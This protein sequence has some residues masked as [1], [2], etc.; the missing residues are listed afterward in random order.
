MIQKDK[1][2]HIWVF[3]FD[4]M[5]KIKRQPTHPGKIIK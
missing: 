2:F 5:K 1:P 3:S 4:K